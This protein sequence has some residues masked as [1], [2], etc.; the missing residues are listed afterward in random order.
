MVASQGVRV[1]PKSKASAPSLQ[2]KEV[3]TGDC[4]HAVLLA[5]GSS[6]ADLFQTWRSASAELTAPDL[7]GVNHE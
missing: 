1:G 4:C 6:N 7:T 2:L 5:E 3:A